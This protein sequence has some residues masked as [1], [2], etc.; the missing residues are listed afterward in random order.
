MEWRH[1]SPIVSA[2]RMWSGKVADAD[3]SDSVMAMYTF[4]LKAHKCLSI[5]F[6]QNRGERGDPFPE[7]SRIWVRKLIV[8]SACKQRCGP[9]VVHSVLWRK[10]RGNIGGFTQFVT[11]STCLAGIQIAFCW[12]NLNNNICYYVNYNLIFMYIFILEYA[13]SNDYIF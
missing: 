2:S 1:C 13:I 9:C 12:K 8:W 10:L 3:F 4:Y 7:N 11:I 5:C 6:H